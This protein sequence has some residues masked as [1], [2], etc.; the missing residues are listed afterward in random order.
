MLLSSTTSTPWG[1]KDFK[2]AV[3]TRRE[4]SQLEK[5]QSETA[6]TKTKEE[7]SWKPT[8]LSNEKYLLETS[9]Q[10]LEIVY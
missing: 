1:S 4:T 2:Q 8:Q 10:Y 3:T 5:L 9:A 6:S 7:K